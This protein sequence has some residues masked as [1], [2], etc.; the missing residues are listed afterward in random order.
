MN[1]HFKSFNPAAGQLLVAYGSGSEVSIEVPIEGGAYL[2]GDTLHSY[3]RG[4]MPSTEQTARL[5]AVASRPA[6]IDSIQALCTDSLVL[7]GYTPT[8]ADLRSQAYPPISEYLD[9]IVKGDLA[10]Q[11]AYIAACLEVKAMFPKPAEVSANILKQ[12]RDL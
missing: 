5:D 9:G 2:T 12:R 4:F 6:G 8:Y 7:T 10:Q 11:E 1:Y 3:V